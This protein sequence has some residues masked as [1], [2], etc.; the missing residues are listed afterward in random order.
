MTREAR[1][2]ELRDE[3]L[4]RRG[5]PAVCDDDEDGEVPQRDSHFAGAYFDDNWRMNSGSL[6]GGTRPFIRR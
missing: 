5:T 4:L 2:I 3:R 1:D 6:D